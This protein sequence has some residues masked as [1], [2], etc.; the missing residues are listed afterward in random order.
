MSSNLSTYLRNKIGESALRGA[1][2]TVP[3]IGYLALATA[4][5]TAANVT[6]NEVQTAAWPAYVRQ[7]FAGGGAMSTGWVALANG[8]SSNAKALSFPTNNG[9][10][11]I[12]IT[13]IGIYDAPTGGNLLFHAPLLVPKTIPVSDLIAFAIGDIAVA[14]T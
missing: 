2:F 8:I 7:D 14:I 6:G 12:V 11:G 13:H 4:D 5:I 10:A 9:V 3:T 1:A